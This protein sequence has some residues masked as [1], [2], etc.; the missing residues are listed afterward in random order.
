LGPGAVYS[1]V[2][3]GGSAPTD[4]KFDPP[5]KKK[6]VMVGVKYTP[7]SWPTGA[8]YPSIHIENIPVFMTV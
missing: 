4:L 5:P 1:V 2:M 3:S 7:N 8:I 6:K